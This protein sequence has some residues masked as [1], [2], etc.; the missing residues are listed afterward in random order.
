MPPTALFATMALRID[1]EPDA[2]AHRDHD[3]GLDDDLILRVT[4]R[5][6]RQ[7]QQQG[8]QEQDVVEADPDVPGSFDEVLREL[9]EAERVAHRGLQGADAG[10]V[11]GQRL[12]RGA[13]GSV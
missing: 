2:V 11:S 5:R 12:V 6:C 3:V 4:G 10:D 13:A 1:G 9:G 7:R 8:E